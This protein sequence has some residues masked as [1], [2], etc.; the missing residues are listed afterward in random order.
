MVG[1]LNLAPNFKYYNYSVPKHD[2]LAANNTTKLKEALREQMRPTQA[3]LIIAGMYV[4][5]SN[6]IQFE[7]DFARSLGKPII[8]VRPYGGERTPQ[9]VVNAAD[10]IVSWSTSSIVNAIRHHSL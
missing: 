4:N 3:V 9:A 7:M 2:A 6:W 10:V 8:G 5:H 1:L